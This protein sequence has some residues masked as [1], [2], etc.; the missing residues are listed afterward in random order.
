MGFIYS[1][2]QLG[3]VLI[4]LSII[5]LLLPIS[6]YGMI[7][8]NPITQEEVNY[9]SKFSAIFT[10]IGTIFTIFNSILVLFLMIFLHKK[11]SVFNF[12]QYKS[13]I[14]KK[15]TDIE[16]IL[17]SEINFFEDKESKIAEIIF[18]SHYG[19]DAYEYR[20][21]YKNE[22]NGLVEILIQLKK[23]YKNFKILRSQLNIDIAKDLDSLEFYSGIIE[24]VFETLALTKP[25]Y[26]YNK[27]FADGGRKD[28]EPEEIIKVAQS[29]SLNKIKEIL[30]RLKSLDSH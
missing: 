23:L 22:S 1:N 15:L 19:F 20:E 29:N 21:L 3:L 30:E 28:V 11:E 18:D 2:N 17:I 5:L 13:D 14:N 7:F 24:E 8:F 4:L 10:T 25:S 12:L 9:Y 6:V 27:S 16:G 26:V